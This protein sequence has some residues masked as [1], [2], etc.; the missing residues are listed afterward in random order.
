MNR[1]RFTRGFAG[2]FGKKRAN[3]N[4]EDKVAIEII[5]SER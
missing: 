2:W 5:V 3:Q 1:F 4:S